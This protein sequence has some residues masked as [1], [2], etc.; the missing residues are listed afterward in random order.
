MT[1]AGWVIMITS[2]SCVVALAS[3]CYYRVLRSPS[4]AQH[5]HA[6]LEIDTKDKG[7]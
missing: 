1:T 5:M 2:I 4:A 6:P 7:T 3:F